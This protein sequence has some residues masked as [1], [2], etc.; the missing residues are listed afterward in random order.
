MSRLPEHPLNRAT[1]LV[2]VL[3]VLALTVFAASPGLHA[4]LHGHED[5]AGMAPGHSHDQGQPDHDHGV[6]VEQAGHECAV[7]LFASGVTA[8]LVFCL[9]MLGRPL[10]A[11]VVWRA[12]DEII[13]SRPRYR[14]VP[15]HAPPAL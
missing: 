13:P 8:L 14:F 7:T 3:C 12:G 2:A 5:A 15:S 9:V 11:G 4:G 1:A 6:P 10:V